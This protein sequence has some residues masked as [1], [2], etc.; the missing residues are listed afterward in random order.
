M[1]GI[2]EREAE[3]YKRLTQ[4]FEKYKDHKFNPFDKVLIYF[5]DRGVSNG[6][7]IVPHIVWYYDK[8]ESK[9]VLYDPTIRFTPSSLIPFDGNEEF[10][11]FKGDSSVV[12]EIKAEL[13]TTKEQKPPTVMNRT[14]IINYLI[15][16]NNYT[17]Y[18]E[19]GLDNPDNNFKK[20][21][22]EL[23]HSVDP[24]FETDHENNYDLNQTQFEYAKQWLTHRMTSDEFFETTE[25]TYDIIFIDGLH[26]QEQVGKDIINGLKCL[27]KGGKIVVHDCLPP[28]EGYQIVPR[29]QVGWCGDVWK[30]IPE[31]KKQNIQFNVVDT[32]LGVGVIDYFENPEDLK[33]IEKSTLTWDDFVSKRNELLNVINETDFIKKY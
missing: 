4:L 33:Y 9:H 24:F 2:T 6:F 31:L 13:E 32:D 20:I 21:N 3:Q 10:I 8:E 30:A 26:T 18:L 15:E 27:N 7:T 19:I 16:K 23:K 17:S 12:T 11:G 1:N 5:K 28:N 14:D 22:C 25:N 29:K